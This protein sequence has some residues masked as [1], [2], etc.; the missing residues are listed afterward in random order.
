MKY[1]R[2]SQQPH[3][4]MNINVGDAVE[5]VSPVRFRYEG[6]VHRYNSTNG[7]HAYGVGDDRHL[8]RILRRIP[9]IPK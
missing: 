1:C 3:L 5:E 8:Q 2:A 9:L 6:S 7:I 4:V